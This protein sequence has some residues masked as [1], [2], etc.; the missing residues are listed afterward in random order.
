MEVGSL[1]C[2]T[3]L[4]LAQFSGPNTLACLPGYEQRQP[5]YLNMAV[6]SCSMGVILYE[7]LV[8]RPPF[9]AAT[10]SAIYKRIVA[11]DF[12]LLASMDPDAQVR[13]SP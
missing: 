13:C 8:G 2:C 11:G 9:T 4:Q 12:E 5:P 3:P 7:M 1:P 10:P 6:F